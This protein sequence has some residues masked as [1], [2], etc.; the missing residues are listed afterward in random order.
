MTNPPNGLPQIAD[1]IRDRLWQ[2]VTN[3]LSLDIQVP[4]K[5]AVTGNSSVSGDRPWIDFCAAFANGSIGSQNFRRHRAVRDIV[6]TACPTEA[7]HYVKLIH[8]LG[9]EFLADRQV[10]DID[11][12]G[13]P[14]R[15]PRLVLGASRSFSPTTLRYLATA[16]W[17]RQMGKL[18][19][20][21]KIVEIGVGFGGLPAMNMIV[22]G[23]PTVLV[24]LPEVEAAASRMLAETGLYPN[25][26]T[27]SNTSGVGAVPL[28]ISNY[29]FTELS[30]ALQDQLLEKYL[31]HA[32]H[33]LIV[34]NAAVF[35][36]GIKGRS[37][38]DLVRWLRDA[39]I[40]ATAENDNELLTPIDKLC[41][42]RLIHW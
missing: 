29:A 38:D 35:A 4:A 17:L 6:E 39:G 25:A 20:G 14:I 21:D 33:G 30:S 22:S 34:S 10:L 13:D 28:V 36:S 5:T 15:C 3:R 9:G 12:W 37:D 42:V 40:P 31:R 26:E 7:R 23:S 1:R 16:L 27:S 11:G 32:Q 19:Q 41:R 24:D 8:M 2:I 18:N